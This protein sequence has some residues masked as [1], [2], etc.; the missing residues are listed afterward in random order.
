M[1]K[2]EFNTNNSPENIITCH[3]QLKKIHFVSHLLFN[4][5][6]FHQITNNNVSTNHSF[7]K[8]SIFMFLMLST[9]VNMFFGLC[10]S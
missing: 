4:L 1:E 3:K 5:N 9:A 8:A 6:F 2:A 10:T 7:V